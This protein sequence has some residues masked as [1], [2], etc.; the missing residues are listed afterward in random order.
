M[1]ML[2]DL[3]EETTILSF[4]PPAARTT[5]ANGTGIDLQGYIG[6]AVAALHSAA[7]TGTTPTLDVKIQDSA[8]NSTFA[9]VTGYAFTQVTDAAASLQDLEIDTRKVRRYVR[10]VTAIT[11]TTPSFTCNCVFRGQ[12]QT[13]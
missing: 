7:G 4:L 11:G 3:K 1:G 6:I 5:G 10:A 2:L 13:Y 9:D 8:D 12:K